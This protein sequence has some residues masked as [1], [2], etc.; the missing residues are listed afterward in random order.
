[1]ARTLIP[2]TNLLTDANLVDVTGTTAD[3]V[4]GHVIRDT[5]VPSRSWPEQTVLRVQNTA[6]TAQSLTVLGGKLMFAADTGIAVSIG[7]GQTQWIGPFTSAHVK[8][9]DGS[10]CLDLGA[11]FTG[12]ITA[13][14]VPRH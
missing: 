12:T 5:A 2:Y 7:A 9:A 4:N 10:I 13:F 6:G 3:P 8:Q 11:G 1:M 14:R